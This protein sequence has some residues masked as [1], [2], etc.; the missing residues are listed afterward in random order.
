MKEKTILFAFR[1]SKELLIILLIFVAGVFFNFIADYSGRGTFLFYLFYQVIFVIGI[2]I[3]IPLYYT[4]FY[5]KEKLETIGI[6]SKK[7]LQA[8]LIGLLIAGITAGGSLIHKTIIL[9]PTDK[10][11]YLVLCLI[12]STLFEEV[13]FRGFLQTKF[14]NYFGMVPAI[15]IAGICFGLYHMG[16]SDM[17]NINDLLILSTVGIV[18]SISFRI[19]KNIIT[20][21]IVNLPNAVI[22]FL[23]RKTYFNMDAAVISLIVTI[24]AITLIYYFGRSSKTAGDIAGQK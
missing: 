18:F 1:P 10:L 24:V 5:R 8:V 21:Y 12:M 3:F 9:P 7:W 11:V 15:I 19:T 6:S 16:Y 13:F 17:R 14:E 20:S 2:C 23:V 22:T 4:V